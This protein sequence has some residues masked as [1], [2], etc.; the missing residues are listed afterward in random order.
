MLAVLPYAEY[1][2]REGLFW[3]DHGAGKVVVVKVGTDAMS[4]AALV[5]GSVGW[6]AVLI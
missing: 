3:R 1:L 4:C 6:R 2:R 5:V